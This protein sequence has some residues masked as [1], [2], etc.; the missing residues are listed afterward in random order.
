MGEDSPK[1]SPV[2]AGSAEELRVTEKETVQ[3]KRS[4]LK[5]RKVRLRDSTKPSGPLEG[6]W[7]LP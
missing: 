6:L 7:C 5:I 1:Q 3:A 4:E 2:Y